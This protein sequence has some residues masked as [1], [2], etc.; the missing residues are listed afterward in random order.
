MALQINAFN[1]PVWGMLEKLAPAFLAGVPTVVKPA[2]QASYLAEAV[3]KEIIASGLL[4]EGSLQL[5]A[6]GSRGLLDLL[7]EQDTVAF[8]GSASTA[9]LL[10]RTARCWNTGCGSAPRRIR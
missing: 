9:A 2:S 8:T 1:F 10:R 3:V 5:V 7:T 6:G 4:P